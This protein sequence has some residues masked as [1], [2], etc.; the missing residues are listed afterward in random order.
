MSTENSFLE[1]VRIRKS[2]GDFEALKGVSLSVARGSVTCVVGPSGS[3]KSTLLRT[4]NMLESIDSGAVFFKGEMIGQVVTGGRRVPVRKRQARSQTLNF[5]MV[6]QG[7]HLFPNLTAL[8]NIMLA[9]VRV[10]GISRSEARARAEKLLARVG[11]AEKG[12]SYPNQLSGGQQQRVAIAR[13]LA[14]GPEVLL[15]DEPTSALD[16]ELVGEVLEVI[17]ELAVEGSTMIIVTHEMHFAR[18][19]ADTIV[20]MDAGEIVEM[21]APGEVLDQPRSARARKFF[22]TVSRG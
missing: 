14:M 16:P 20:M 6:F 8:D 18:E 21:G 1:L 19:V 7:F 12:E 17:R 2:Y 15:F 4:V 10:L 5:G 22:T 13:A 11:L 9:P 3:G